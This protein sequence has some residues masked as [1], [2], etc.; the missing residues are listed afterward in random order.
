M[1]LRRAILLLLAFPFLQLSGQN[2]DQR[3]DEGASSFKDR[4][5]IRTNVVDWILT[6]PNIAFDYDVVNTPYDK[7][8]IGINLKYNWNTNHTYVPKL[9]YNLF[10]LR[11]DYRFYWRQQ[12]Y[13]DRD[14]WGD[15]ER[16]WINSAKGLDRLRARVSSFRAAENPRKN[17]SFFVGPYLSASIFSIKL[18][19][20]ED[21]L[22]HQGIAY[23][24]GLTGGI[25]MPLYGYKNGA[26]IDIEIGG[27]LGWH[28][29]SYDLF[30]V[31]TESNCYHP[32]G[33]YSKWMKY[34][35]IADA[36][37]SLVYRFRTIAK[38]H[39]E[40]NY[41]L[42]DRR[43]MAI[44]IKRYN[45]EVKEYN[46]GIKEAKNEIDKRNQEIALYKQTVE[47][48]NGFNTAYSLEY[49]TPYAYMMEAPRKYTRH[50]K[51]TLPKIEI[52]SFGQITDP[53]LLSV[54]A[55]IDSIPHVT[56][57]Q[58]DD[59][60]VKQYN[61]IINIGH[62][63]KRAVY[64][65][66]LIKSIY[67][68]LN[69]HLIK[70]DNNEKLVASIFNTEIHTEKVDKFDVSEQKNKDVDITYKDSVRTVQ[71]SDNE[72]VE[73]RN[74][75]KQ[76]AWIDMQNRKKGIYIRRVEPM[77]TK[78]IVEPIAT[79]SINIDSV[80][81]TSVKLDSIGLDS[82]D[83]NRTDTITTDSIKHIEVVTDSIAIAPTGMVAISY[84]HIPHRIW[85]EWEEEELFICLK[86]EK[87]EE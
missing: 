84:N 75:I 6:T 55:S 59:E 35:L 22:G 62:R 15:W 60:F 71:M 41:G 29:V 68:Q 53:I 2:V 61:S 47:S 14:C 77:A 16:E 3:P 38:Q 83:Y 39:K 30:S 73:W 74:S 40:I 72:K 20:T 67:N 12:P 70:K 26:A 5:A 57:A 48:E 24:G 34:P 9:V 44:N 76:K 37:V 50:D 11:L 52:T 54:R 87:D 8:S 78:K 49:L 69:E 66:E 27:S 56:S 63:D 45:D 13:D 82:I 4:I 31:D 17:V 7:K 1:R 58:I 33:H 79:D 28:F 80:K 42:L 36:R 86:E 65:S 81:I 21:A 23:G 25:A 51:D 32:Q 10:D 19:A 46:N 64:R 43:Y 18:N 85:E